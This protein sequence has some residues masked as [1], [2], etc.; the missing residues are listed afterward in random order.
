MD[1]AEEDFNTARD[2]LASKHLDASAFHAQQAAEKSLKAL[3]IQLHG[4]FD[5]IHDLVSLAK[6]DDA[7]NEII[8]CCLRL[9]PYYVVTRYPDVGEPITREI[10]K[11]LLDDSMKVIK[12]ATRRL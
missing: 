7:P 9:A 10:V 5:K 6:T 3:Q 1:K 11:E 12:W 4:R 8:N 2:C